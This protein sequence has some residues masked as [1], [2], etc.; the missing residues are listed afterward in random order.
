VQTLPN[1]WQPICKFRHSFTSRFVWEDLKKS[2]NSR[3]IRVSWAPL[4]QFWS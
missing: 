1:F 2:A 3:Q 4:Y